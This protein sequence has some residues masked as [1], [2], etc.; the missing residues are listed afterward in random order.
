MRLD[1]AIIGR[2]RAEQFMGFCVTESVNA[3]GAV[4]L[5]LGHDAVNRLTQ[6]LEAAY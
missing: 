2:N 4:A 3:T 1:A 6:G 5:Q